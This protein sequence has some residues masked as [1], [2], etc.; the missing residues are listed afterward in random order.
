MSSTRIYTQYIESNVLN[1]F[2]ISRRRSLLIYVVRYESPTRDLMRSLSRDPSVS[3]LMSDL[4]LS[5]LA[6][7]GL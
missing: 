7:A 2:L 3:V 1:Y 5:G 6:H 4:L